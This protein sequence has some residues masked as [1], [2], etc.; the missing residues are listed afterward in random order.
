MTKR[1]KKLVLFLV[2]WCMP[3]LLLMRVC[4]FFTALS[5]FMGSVPSREKAIVA[6]VLDVVSM[7]LQIVVFGPQVLCD[8][9][10]ANTG[11]R[12][13]KSRAAKQRQMEVQKYK[14]ELS[15]DFS[16]AYS[17]EEFLSKT[18]T[19]A[20]EALRDWLSAYGV[21]RPEREQL[22]RLVEQLISSPDVAIALSPILNQ[23]NL[24]NDSK[25]KLCVRLAEVCRSRPENE[26]L[27]ILCSIEDC[28][29]DVELKGM[30]SGA[31]DTIDKALRR[32]V[33]KRE[34]RR[35]SEVAA[36]ARRK[37]E[38]EAHR[39]KV[40]ESRRERERRDEELRNLAS[41]MTGKPDDFKLALEMKDEPIVATVW[42]SLLSDSLKP[43]P[44]ENIRA[45][46]AKV[47]EPGA[48]MQCYC[49]ELFRRPELTADDLRWLYPR[50][51]EKLQ[52]RSQWGRSG[53]QCAGALIKNV[54]FPPDLVRESYDDQRLVE[55]RIH[56]V[57]RHRTSESADGEEL[58]KLRIECDELKREFMNGKLPF[59][60]YNAKR[61]E[62]SKKF[63]PTKCPNDWVRTLP[64][65]RS[66]GGRHE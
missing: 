42:A 49:R 52:E 36:A 8:Y 58:R 11:E 19:P 15:R 62:L 54:N 25:R 24:S 9:I 5:H 20:R 32:I 12:G 7:P 4:G 14:E 57:Y 29:T 66:R 61:F 13:R 65:G 10:R 16:K 28:L 30:I 47:T 6:G 31:D 37:E 35:R 3:G 23:K 40:E 50:I 41:N 39:R 48:R 64:G 53:S 56:Y 17:T 51:L 34:K 45:L 43:L 59:D 55:L 22:D 63:L 2:C 46:A 27:S 38:E 21:N 33:E 26:R 1:W 18:N 60:Q 44:A